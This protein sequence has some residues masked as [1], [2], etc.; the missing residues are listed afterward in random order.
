MHAG[1]GRA[2][3]RG[4]P[5]SGLARGPQGGDLGPR[6][7]AVTLPSG[8]GQRARRGWLRRPMGRGRCRRGGAQAPTSCRCEGRPGT[9]EHRDPGWPRPR[10]SRD[11]GVHG[12][13][14]SC[15]PT[16]LGS[17]VPQEDTQ[18]QGRPVTGGSGPLTRDPRR[19]QEQ[20]LGRGVA[21][22]PASPSGS[23]LRRP[24][25][26]GLVGHHSPNGAQVR[27]GRP[28]PGK[29]WCCVRQGARVSPGWA[30]RLF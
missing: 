27:V 9:L 7:K 5:A 6:T 25:L 29:P 30:F 21:A 24:G 18:R 15:C 16:S 19:S 14:L 17:L 23:R 3:P 1:R 22:A 26:R 8:R 12:R 4:T 10:G 11:P 20:R 13:N 28:D 2:G